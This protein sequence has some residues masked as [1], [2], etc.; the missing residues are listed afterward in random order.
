MFTMP[1]FAAAC[2]QLTE[3]TLICRHPHDNPVTEMGVPFDAVKDAHS[4]T[5]ELVNACKPLPDFDTLQIV[6]LLLGTPSPRCA[7][8]WNMSLSSV[9][10][11]E[12]KLREQVKGVR[13]LAVDC[14]NDPKTGCR[15][16]EGRKKVTL[17]VIELTSC[18]GL[19][20]FGLESVKVEAFEV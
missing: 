17:R 15:E 3:L 16:G 5:L 6:Y 4:A 18:Y 19:T 1:G 2:P 14:L 20:G 11:R 9:E 12:Q 7:D 13:D 10:R 8:A